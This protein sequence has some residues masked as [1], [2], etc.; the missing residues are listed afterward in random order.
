MVKL[1]AI[2]LVILW[3]AWPIPTP[4]FE[5]NQDDASIAVDEHHSLS[6]QV[7][8]PIKLVDGIDIQVENA[9][10]LPNTTPIELTIQ[11][12]TSGNIIRSIHMRLG[13][14]LSSDKLRFRF[15]PTS[16]EK[17]IVLTISGP[18]TREKHPLFIRYARATHIVSYRLFEPKAQI[19]SLTSQILHTNTIGTD[20][21]L[22]YEAGGQ[23]A[24]HQNPYNR[25]LKGN[26][27]DNDS[28]ATYLP[29]FYLLA[30]ATQLAGLHTYPQWIAFWRPIFLVFALATAS[31]LFAVFWRKGLFLLAFFVAGFF[32][33]NRW[34]L[35]I[36]TVGLFD[37]IPIFFLVISLLLIRKRPFL[38]LCILGLSL[39]FRHIGAILL[40]LYFIEIWQMSINHKAKNMVAG[41]VSFIAIPLAVS[42]PFM[43]LNISSFTKSMLFSFTRGPVTHFS[44]P[45]VDAFLGLVG[46]A[47]KIEMLALLCMVYVAYSLRYV[48]FFVACILA[49]LVFLNFHSVWFAQYMAYAAPIGMLALLEIAESRKS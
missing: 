25:I 22:T 19:V 26:L 6:Q 20:I 24:H 21:A 39:S 49:F 31:V 37:F 3:A 18:V 35:Y 12:T 29:S 34:S 1:G 48:G 5:E 11:S 41:F 43:L 16:V 32:L 33:F 17:D 7:S 45:S 46:P 28:Y 42:L 30:A 40:P 4:V 36:A 15:P 2:A 14:I 8:S 9:N 47:A 23:I 38:S 27:Q 44:V 10:E 13:D